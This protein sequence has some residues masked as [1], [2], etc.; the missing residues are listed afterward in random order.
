MGLPLVIS[1][2]MTLATIVIHALALVGILYFIRWQD[3]LKRT[4]A[5]T[6]G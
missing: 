4:S 6:H 1:L 3:Q 5:S 2:L